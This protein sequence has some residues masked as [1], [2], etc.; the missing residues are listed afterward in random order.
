MK[1]AGGAN[2]Q[3][4]AGQNAY[5]LQNS[6]RLLSRILDRF[7]LVCWVEQSQPLLEIS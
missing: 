3:M 5:H 1:L 2:P 6:N 7:T 4:M